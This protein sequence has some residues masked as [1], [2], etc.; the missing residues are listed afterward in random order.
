MSYLPVLI[1]AVILVLI[2]LYILLWRPRRSRSGNCAGPTPEAWTIGPTTVPA[3]PPEPVAAGEPPAPETKEPELEPV[4]E[5]AEE[6]A[7]DQV[8]EPA[9]PAIEVEPATKSP[10]AATEVE[11]EDPET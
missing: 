9:E 11:I 1:L 6:P 5:A 10:E 3:R 2:I 7:K 8:G 4:D